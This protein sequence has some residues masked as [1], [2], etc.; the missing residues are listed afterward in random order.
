MVDFIEGRACYGELYDN[1]TEACLLCAHELTCI[2]KTRK[3]NP[4]KKKERLIGWIAENHKGIIS[5]YRAGV[6]T[7]L[8]SKSPVSLGGIVIVTVNAI[9]PK[10]ELE[11][12]KEGVQ[13]LG[14]L[15]TKKG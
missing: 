1:D 3:M 7:R 15:Y 8:I 13:T 2:E 10:K 14:F 9:T 5:H 6:L 12:L 4:Q 11:F